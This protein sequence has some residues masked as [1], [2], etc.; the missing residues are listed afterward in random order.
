MK[1]QVFLFWITLYE[2]L[3]R[4]ERRESQRNAEV[5]GSMISLSGSQFLSL[6]LSAVNGFINSYF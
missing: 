2:V 1:M 6:R 5:K 4:R 3:N